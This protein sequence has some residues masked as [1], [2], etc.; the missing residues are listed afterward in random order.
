MLETAKL[1]FSQGNVKKSQKWFNKTVEKY[2]NFYNA[3][4]YFLKLE[5]ICGTE[6]SAKD[7]LIGL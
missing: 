7:V 6:E 4:I 2:Q 3:W 5:K 1:F